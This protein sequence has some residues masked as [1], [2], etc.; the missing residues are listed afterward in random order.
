MSFVN[1]IVNQVF[2]VNMDKDTARLKKISEMLY[3]QNVTFERIQGVPGKDVKY[4]DRLTGFCNSFCA[5]SAKGC[6][7][8]HRNIWD[9]SHKR[10]YDAILVFE[11]D[12]NIPDDFSVQLQKVWNKRPDDY[13]I[14][15][16]GIHGFGVEENNLASIFQKITDMEP[17]K[18]NNSFL[19]VKGITG[20]YAM[21]ISKAGIDKLR[22]NTINGH[23][24]GQISIW[25][26][27]YNFKLYS[28]NTFSI[29]PNEDVVSN[30]STNIKYP[31][32]ANYIFKQIPA[33]KI[34]NLDYLANL[35]MYKIGSLNITNAIL[36]TFFITLFV[37]QRYK[38][39]ILAYLIAEF[40]VTPSFSEA[41]PY[42]TVWAAAFLISY[43]FY[44]NNFKNIKRFIKA[45]TR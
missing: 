45:V 23:I 41:K 35:S 37:P 8:S 44:G 16:L 34:T 43:P 11:D 3:K 20:T 33:T 4:D 6:A 31:Y 40:I 12:V 25:T 29:D 5:D 22:S 17:N 21:L 26:Q 36:L 27:I 14:I 15:L 42:F 1:S 32:Y 10:G 18:F 9:I 30:N 2:V 13:D 28:T 24:D 19:S 7:L 38:Y 39:F